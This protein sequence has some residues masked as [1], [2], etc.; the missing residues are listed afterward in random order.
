M[1]RPL[2]GLGLAVLGLPLK[3]T[4]YFV[5]RPVLEMVLNEVFREQRA[6][7]DLDAFRNRTLGIRFT[8]LDLHW[9]FG[10]IDE[11]FVAL[12]PGG[13]SDAVISGRLSDFLR[14]ISQTVDPD[15]LFFHRRLNVEGDTE[16]G[17]HVKNLLDSMDWSGIPAP[18]V[19]TLGQLASADGH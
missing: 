1:P 16:L 6:D 7:G 3:L 11:E 12:T 8:D 2:A 4:P 9:R 19:E 14:L 18:V 15:T 10:F 13:D 17:L 5:Q